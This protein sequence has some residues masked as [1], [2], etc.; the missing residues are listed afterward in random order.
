MA[1]ILCVWFPDWRLR[2][3]DAPSGEPCQVVD[4]R[5]RVIACNELAAADGVTLGM[6]RRSAEAVCPIVV[7]L[8]SDPAAEMVAFEPVLAA[9]ETMVP[10]V[11]P[12][13]PGLAYV[14]L[15]GAVGYYGG[16]LAAL[17]R[18]AKELD[19]ID[20]AG[21][22]LGVA[23]GPFSSRHAAIQAT[24]AD[25][26]VIVEDDAEFL[27]SLD[28]SVIDHDDLVAT[29]RWLG[30]GTLG[31]LAGLPRDA[32]VSRFGTVGLHA[33]RVATGEQRR[34]SPRDVPD[35][36]AVTELFDPPLDNLEQAAF[37][38]RSLASRLIDQTRVSGVVPHRVEIDVE[39]ADGTV[40]TRTWRSADPFD[41][42]A[43]AE[44][45]RWQLRAWLESV[46]S[47][48]RGGLAR[49]TITPADLSD[50]GRQLGL[51]EDAAV[52]AEVDR[53]LVQTQALVGV[54]N[55]LQAL[56]Q[57]GRDPIERIAWHRWGEEPAK[58]ERDPEAP[59]RGRVPGASPALTPPEPHRLEVEWDTGMPVRV[60]LGSR[61][62]PVLSWAGPWRRM[63]R[64][65]LGEEAADRYQ[66]VTSA[67]AF[68]CEVRDGAAYL[69]GVYD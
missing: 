38:A 11:E 57:G 22:R 50:S 48:I 6:Q 17:E 15:D 58:G 56:P 36:P 16:E 8:V 47:G 24:S 3:P 31:E 12:S 21:Y 18:I 41:E 14:M 26:I 34:P 40:R 66:L 53:A 10:R 54:D 67:G 69:T 29:F 23:S 13:E 43:L 45:V 62:E 52:A 68:L 25:P 55:V 35:D 32:V 37:V 1:R 2:R 46:S 5:N 28:V 42:G 61:W 49:I 4:D 51:H 20:I 27:A 33:H 9:I 63:G 30:I 44:R 64:W 65:W 19:A 39:A 59:W 60:R 7:T